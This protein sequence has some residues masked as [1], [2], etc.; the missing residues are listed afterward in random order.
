[1]AELIPVATDH[2]VQ[3]HPALAALARLPGGEDA[4]ALRAIAL[5][6]LVELAAPRGAVLIEGGN[7]GAA[8][9][10]VGDRVPAGLP[11]LWPADPFLD[12]SPAVAVLDRAAYPPDL[13]A[14]L[15]EAGIGT[16]WRCALGGDQPHA[17]LLFD[18]A[19]AAALEWA[20]YYVQ[21]LAAY[22]ANADLRAQLRAQR[23]QL[24]AA[25]A[26]SEITAALNSHL[27]EP[28]VLQLIA[29]RAQELLGS[30]G[31]AINLLE[32]DGRSVRTLV[33][34]GS[35]L[36]PLIDRV[37]TTDA[38]L[39]ARVVLTGQPAIWTTDSGPVT[40]IP[41]I[42]A[43]LVHPLTGPFGPIG[44]IGMLNTSSGHTFGPGDMRLLELF[45]RQAALAITNARMIER[46]RHEAA[47][48]ASFNQIIEALLLAHSDDEVQARLVETAARLIPCESCYFAVYSGDLTTAVVRHTQTLPGAPDL[49]GIWNP[50]TDWPDLLPA[51]LKGD[52]IYWGEADA[53]DKTP[54][55]ATWQAR[56]ITSSILVPV[57][58]R[59]W[60]L[61]VLGFANIL[62][63]P[64]WL[65]LT[66]DLLRHLAAQVAS[67]LTTARLYEETREH[68]AAVRRLSE[69]VHALNNVSVQIQAARHADEVFAQTFAGLRSLGLHAVVVGSDA[70]GQALRVVAHSFS[71]WEPTG[72]PGATEGTPAA[73]PL[74]I[75][76]VPAI[77]QAMRTREVQFSD[78][79]L[80]AL[81]AYYPGASPEVVAAMSDALGGMAHAVVAP[82]VARDRLLGL[83][84]IIGANLQSGDQAALAPLA[85]QA[86][87]AL[88]KA[89]LYDAM[90]AAYRFS[91][92]LID[93][94]S[95]GLAVV[96][97]EGRHVLANRAFCAMVGFQ[98]QDL[99]GTLPP[100]PYWP[101][102][103][104]EPSRLDLE[105]IMSG[106]A[107][108]GRELVVNLCRQDGTEFPAG[109]TPGEVHDERGRVT[110]Y[111]VVVR[112]LTERRQLEAEAAQARAAREADRLKSE[113]LSTVSHEL[114]TP[115][116]AIKGFTSTMLRYGDRLSLA[117]QREFLNDIEASSDRLAELVGNLLNMSRLEAALLSME[118][119]PLDL[120]PLVREE[121]SGFWP[122]LTGRKQTL[123][124]DVP[125][126]LPLVQADPRRM[127][128]VLANLLDN[129][130]KYTPSG[131]RVTVRAY[132]EGPEIVVTVAD[133][134]PGIPPEHL[135]RVFDPFHR[136]DSGL[137]RTVGGTG[138]GLAITRRI[139]DAH[140]G[141][142]EVDSTLGGGATFTVRVPISDDPPP[143]DRAAE[144]PPAP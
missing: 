27:S 98:A 91:E 57:L 58:Y 17:V 103:D 124:L 140:G 85:S 51:I 83:L 90:Q 38:S 73:E 37:Y 121:A 111:L 142:I 65:P 92:S 60:L 79:I 63:M 105:Q 14:C 54:S 81:A 77:D 144:P 22:L 62:N 50:Q 72:R 132:A 110:G 3:A 68:L 100:H 138:L 26:V 67:A 53:D 141:R 33:V 78:D 40:P 143:A 88:D 104:D 107:Q 32:P 21:Q 116:A 112:D 39:A 99:D 25:E 102:V 16:I 80:P 129:A 76:M 135:N 28:D 45:A 125:D 29:D 46:S 96:D 19:H 36:T 12:T 47:F 101:G 4:A 118:A 61:G 89:D 6:D 122:R 117:E 64:N 94:M 130:A 7:G 120:A 115:L 106:V 75:M 34:S 119:E 136:V 10:I 97:T 108:P 23:I 5:G 49:R 13:A 137:T 20:G 15:G 43:A 128:Q 1:V 69:R 71:D 131:G 52:L 74:P 59:G 55:E 82:L 18:P 66:P 11:D 93:S 35:Q 30:D 127:R 48:Q 113:L 134:G 24:E 86:A 8:R 84:I 139:L 42:H 9:V 41:G 126:R 44:S 56:G 2:A 31:V 114:R 87:I 95:E 109:M 123:H 70:A 133:T